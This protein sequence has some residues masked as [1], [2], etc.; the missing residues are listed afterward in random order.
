M[1]QLHQG[2]KLKR[3]Q[4]LHKKALFVKPI[5]T[6][7]TFD[8]F[9][10]IDHSI[11]RF[12]AEISHTLILSILDVSTSWTI[13]LSAMWLWISAHLV[14]LQVWSFVFRKTQ[15]T[16]WVFNVSGIED[17]YCTSSAGPLGISAVRR[18][19]ESTWEI[20]LAYRENSSGLPITT[21]PERNLRKTVFLTVSLIQSINPFP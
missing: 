7:G 16:R 14:K 5:F 20:W 10:V 11:V 4:L 18:Q 21:L 8:P 6:F 13:P 3:W 1:S 15:T 2:Q 12:Q 17:E 9:D 19:S